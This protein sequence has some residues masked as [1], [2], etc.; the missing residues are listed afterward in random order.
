MNFNG[1][2]FLCW[3]REIHHDR[4]RP[5]R[6]RG[7][8]TL[9]YCDNPHAN[10]NCKGNLKTLAST[11]LDLRPLALIRVKTARTHIHL[12]LDSKKTSLPFATTASRQRNFAGRNPLPKQTDPVEMTEAWKLEKSSE[13]VEDCQGL[14]CAPRGDLEKRLQADA[15]LIEHCTPIAELEKHLTLIFLLLSAQN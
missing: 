8:G 9:G 10:H 2:H 3:R 6:L 7:M 4:G 14:I 1:E 5:S 11:G 13:R 12:R 15:S